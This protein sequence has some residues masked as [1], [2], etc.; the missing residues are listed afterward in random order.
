MKITIIQTGANPPEFKDRFAPYADF[1][2]RML[3]GADPT[4]STN[5]VAP[6]LGEPLPDV[7]SLEAI[8]ITGSASSAYDETPWIDELR[9]FI[10]SAYELSLPMVGICFGH[11]IMAHALG[12][13][14]QKSA[15]GWGLGL[16]EY[17]LEN[18]P[19]FM[20]GTPE[21]LAVPASHQDQV[22]ALPPGAAVIM[23]SQFTPLAGLAYASGA[24]ISF[25]PHPEFSKDLA[26]EIFRRRI[27][28]PLTAEEVEH[29]VR[30]LDGR[31]DS[32]ALATAIA[33][34]YR[35][36]TATPV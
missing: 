31:N 21:L 28:N 29:A 17:R 36:H 32:S 35:Q 3:T 12:G 2:T 9:R 10:Q 24:A 19:S 26:T 6:V 8:I 15:R 14:V 23:G 20:N 13:T 1:F 30:S 33:R 7:K 25:Q 22:V 27:D 11:Q 5:V 34:F 18:P 16:H 4:L